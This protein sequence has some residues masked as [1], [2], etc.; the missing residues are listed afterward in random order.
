MPITGNWLIDTKL[1][2]TERKYTS[3]NANK[4]PVG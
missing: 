4:Q 3:K 1:T 2:I